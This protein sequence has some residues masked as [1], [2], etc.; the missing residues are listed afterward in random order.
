MGP[1]WEGKVLSG[2]S[3]VGSGSS[4]DSGALMGSLASSWRS[5]EQA[6]VTE[7]AWRGGVK[8]REALAWSCFGR[9]TDLEGKGQGYK[10]IQ[11]QA[12]EKK[13]KF[14]SSVFF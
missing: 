3:G 10:H 6:H 11:R 12:W 7:G 1:A 8:S 14:C 13:V 9:V 2:K 4:G 5:R